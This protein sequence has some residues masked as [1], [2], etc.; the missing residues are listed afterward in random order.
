MVVSMV[1]PVRVGVRIKPFFAM[2]HQEIHAERI[3]RRDKDA[4]QGRVVREAS[5]PYIGSTGSLDN[6]LF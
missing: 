2:K 3:Q 6:V 5:T 1:V 4:N